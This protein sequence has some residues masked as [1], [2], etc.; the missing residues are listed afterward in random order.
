MKNKIFYFIKKILKFFDISVVRHSTLKKIENN[1]NQFEILKF[2]KEIPD[3]QKLNF[4]KYIDESQSSVMQDLFV[5]SELDFKKNGFFLDIGAAYSI[6]KNNTFL[7]E[8]KFNWKGII[9]EPCRVYKNDLLKNRNN[10]I[11]FN[12]IWSESNQKIIFNETYDP[13]LS[14]RD[15]FTNLDINGQFRI[16]KNTYEIETLS[17]NDLLKKYNAPKVI[18][19]LSLDT[20]GSEFE[21]LSTFNFNDY[22]ISVITVEH[23]YGPNREKISKLLKSRGY[24][25]KFKK[26][27]YVDDWYVLNKLK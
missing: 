27:S 2:I 15:K 13:E 1:N 23:A 11:N 4:I 24:I 14:T 26:F 3:K 8:K 16:S 18:D 9:S 19:Y 22:I 12:Y 25:R 6:K 7:L 21:I 20:E 5:L 10:Q 17:L